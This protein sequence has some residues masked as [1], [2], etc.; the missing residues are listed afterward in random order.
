MT[1]KSFVIWGTG[2]RSGCF[3]KSLEEAPVFYID[4]D[5]CKK[6][7]FFFG[8]RIY[9]PSEIYDWKSYFIVIANSFYEEIKKQLLALGLEEDKDFVYYGK[10]VNNAKKIEKL[11]EELKN[12]MVQFK[13]NYQQYNNATLIF[14]SMISFDKNSYRLYNEA[15]NLL[16]NKNKFLLISE[17]HAVE[18]K[19]QKGM[20]EFPYFCLPLM[21]WQNFHLVEGGFGKIAIPDVVA[22]YI[23]EKD[24]RVNALVDFKGKNNNIAH[25]YAENFIYYA[26]LYLR[27]MFDFI[28]PKKVLIWNQFYPFHILIKSICAEKNI[29]ILYMEYG[30]LPGTYL[31]ERMGQMGESYPATHSEEF[32]KLDITDIDVKKAKEVYEY[33]HKSGINRKEQP[34]S[35]ELDRAKKR[36]KKERPIIVYA[37]QNDY[38][39]GLY[40][41]TEHT[42]KYH[43]PI[44][45]GSEDA[46]LFLYEIAKKNDWNFI[47]KPHP[48]CIKSKDNGTNLPEEA[49]VIEKCNINELVEWADINVTI[50]STVGYVS[51]IRRRP[52]VMLGYTQLKDK[53]CT[54]Q[55]FSKELVEEEIKKA[56]EFGYTKKQEEE[57]I[58]HIARLIKYYLYDDMAERDIR[59]GKDWKD[60]C[61]GEKIIF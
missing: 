31:V 24:Y 28:C 42:K 45:K 47:Y 3:S 55:A 27:E 20:I 33:L 38:E 36:I 57:F 51:L 53:G 4:N 30:V 15:F 9:H 34:V 14:G 8:K 37:G 54:Y 61:A 5:I 50:L 44:F 60:I 17:T 11:I 52:I 13:A 22:N 6:G 16:S 58:M 19:A 43:S 18:E 46:A 23:K 41:Y 59:F 40:P 39:S 1:K 49:I 21:L 48:L 10:V 35:D 29:D 56:L 32:Q 2:D 26:D 25:G 7:A 12:S